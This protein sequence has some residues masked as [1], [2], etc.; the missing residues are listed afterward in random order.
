MTEL[1]TRP[2]SAPPRQPRP[3]WSRTAWWSGWAPARRWPSC[4]PA[5]GAPRLD[6][7]CAA[8]SPATEELAV[9]HG[10]DR[11][12]LHRHRPPRPGHRRRGPGGS[13]GLA[14]QGRWRGP[15]PRAHRGRR[16]RP[17]RG[18]RVVGQ[19]GRP[20]PCPGAARAPAFGLAATLRALPGAVLR[21]AP[22]TPDGGVLADYHGEVGRP[23]PPGRHARRRPGRRL[24]RPVPAVHGRHRAHR[25]G[26]R[27][28]DAP[29]RL[30]TRVP[31]GHGCAQAAEKTTGSEVGERK[32]S[33]RMCGSPV[34]R[35]E[36]R[37][38][39]R[40]KTRLSSAR[41]SSRARCM[42]RHMCGPW[43]KAMCGTA[44]AGRCR[45]SRG[46]PSGS[47]RGWPSRCAG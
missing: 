4:V 35:L 25:P 37:S 18:H 32:T 46:R 21:D 8:T 26:R 41:V 9:A 11:P 6:I 45:R 38:G 7:T 17:L 5:L 34:A 22:L 47:R 27:G 10:L 33:P 44:P 12:A 29:D 16:R 40:S 3:R 14:G 31:G 30:S 20:A 36:A 15:D 1:T 28:G 13:G 19:A 43:A 24:P 42:P 23:R 2:R 39:R